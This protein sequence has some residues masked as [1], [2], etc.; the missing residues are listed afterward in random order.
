M[1]VKNDR[2]QAG[3]VFNNGTYTQLQLLVDRRLISYDGDGIE[4]VPPVARDLEVKF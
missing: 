3:G 2:M 4:L 1:I